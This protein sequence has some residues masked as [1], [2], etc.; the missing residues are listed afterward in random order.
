MEKVDLNIENYNLN[1]ILELFKLDYNFDSSDLKKAKRVVLMT[2]PDKSKLSKDYFLFYSK[3]YKMLY[4]V[5]EFRNKEEKQTECDVK[6][7]NIGSDEDYNEHK[8]LI[9]GM[10]KKE[11]FHSW[12]NRLFDKHYDKEEFNEEGYGNWFKSDDN[13]YNK[14]NANFTQMTNNIDNIKQQQK[15]HAMVRKVDI[16]Q[17]VGH[18]INSSQLHSNGVQDYSSGFGIGNSGIQYN[19]LK[20]AF[21]ETL[22]PVSEQD[23]NNKKKYNNIQEMQLDRTQN[24][25]KPLSER[26]SFDILRKRERM[27]NEI[28]NKTAYDLIEQSRKNNDQTSM[29]WGS[30]KVLGHK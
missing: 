19:D 14:D 26:E 3:A 15:S 30:I 12:F 11:K 27:D 7:Q 4:Y 28:S 29:F 18:N 1:E 20:Q 8:Q 2:H 6:Y 25:V 9:D 22:I 21:Q 16:E 17:S 24:N 23:Y 13:M 5:F 10:N